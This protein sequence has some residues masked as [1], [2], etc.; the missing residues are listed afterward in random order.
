MMEDQFP[1]WGYRP[2]SLIRSG[3]VGYHWASWWP[4]KTKGERNWDF[5][6]LETSI[7]G[8]VPA[9]GFVV[10][11]LKF[12]MVENAVQ[13][14]DVMIYDLDLLYRISTQKNDLWHEVNVINDVQLVSIVWLFSTDMQIW[15][16]ILNAAKKTS[17]DMNFRIIEL[18]LKL[19]L[20]TTPG[21]IRHSPR[22]QLLIFWETTPAKTCNM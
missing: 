4:P 2:N 21:R 8:G 10:G 20:N 14:I 12:L 7:F 11:R 6:T 18:Q 22:L 19:F 16:S 13:N 5:P 1:P 9:V 3:S 15:H 17:I